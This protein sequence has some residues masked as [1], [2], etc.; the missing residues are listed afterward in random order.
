MPERRR[1][2]RGDGS[3]GQAVRLRTRA[4]AVLALV[5]L[6][7]CSGDDAPAGPPPPEPGYLSV[8]LGLPSGGADDAGA[9]IAIAGP[10]IDSLRSAG[11]Y[12]LFW[13]PSAAGVKAILAGRLRP[14]RAL[15]FRVPDVAVAYQ[16]ELLEVAASETFQQR[17]LSGYSVE[18]SKPPSP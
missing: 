7:A 9:L 17:E 3:G 5:A 6:S 1:Q 10:G 11:P 12:E 13:G 16:V 18:V 4:L 14:G 15:E 2:V 8:T